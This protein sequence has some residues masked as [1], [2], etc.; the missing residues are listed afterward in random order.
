MH[1]Q[2]IV[3]GNW[4]M[5]KSP[6]EAIDFVKQLEARVCEFASVEK[7]VAP[8]SLALSGV[9]AALQGASLLVAAQNA[10][11]AG[12]G[13][14]TGQIAASMLRGLAQFVILGH[15]EVRAHLA[16]TDANVNRKAKAALAAGLQPI[17][18]VGESLAQN[19]AGATVDFVRGQVSAALDGIAAAEMARV[20]I[21]YEPI[22]AIGTG[23]S[24]TGEQADRIIGA[25]VR[26][27]VRDLYNDRVADAM[28]IQYGGS[29]KPGN[30]AEFMVQPNIDGALVGGASLD[31][32]DFA[33]L[34][35]IAARVKGS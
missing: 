27:P 4:K 1:R 9:S 20:V 16:E 6:R 31:V 21:A 5:H 19:E 24:A 17:I 3:V 30:M 25:A 15:S 11:W 7:A 10:H 12:G 26:E 28:R 35:E 32:D 29:V 2:P 13:A 34:V 18:A 8:T 22:W 14:F 33:A 23:K